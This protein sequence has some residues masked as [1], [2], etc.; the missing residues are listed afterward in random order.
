MHRFSLIPRFHSFA[1]LALSA[2]AVHLPLTSRALPV[3][4]ASPVSVT[5]AFGSAIS[6][7]ANVTA[8]LGTTYVWRRDGVEIINGGRYSGATTAILNISDANAADNGSYE[9][10]MT[11]GDGSA[12]TTPANVTVSQNDAALDASFPNPLT[13]FAGIS[14]ML[15]LP[16]GRVLLACYDTN[17]GNFPLTAA[18]WWWSSQTGSFRTLLREW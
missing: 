16:D 17:L 4:N 18:S 15:P 2:V 14:D 9:L 3:V 11:D 1:V 5:P 8:G 6:L 7:S 13:T 12:C 10:T